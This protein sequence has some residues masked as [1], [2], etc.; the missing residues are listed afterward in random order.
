[1]GVSE[2]PVCSSS[3]ESSESKK[4][5]VGRGQ[6][7]ASDYCARSG[8]RFEAECENSRIGICATY[9]GQATQPEKRKGDVKREGG[10]KGTG[11]MVH[12][13]LQELRFG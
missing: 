8:Q 13:A 2:R 7:R 10:E 12:G 6:L 9:G 5:K 1:M 4:S 11:K 3:S